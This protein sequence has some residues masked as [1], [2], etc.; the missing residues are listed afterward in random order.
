MGAQFYFLI[1][2][3]KIH[4]TR[5]TNCDIENGYPRPDYKIV[6]NV[7]NLVRG[8]R[9]LQEAYDYVNLFMSIYVTVTEYHVLTKYH[10]I[11]C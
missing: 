5:A 8:N 1:G 9:N 3:L 10:M 2:W 7:V 6:H 11:C 4:R